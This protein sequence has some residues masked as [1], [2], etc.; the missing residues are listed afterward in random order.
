MVVK[1]KTE[2]CIVIMVAI[3]AVLVIFLINENDYTSSEKVIVDESN[4]LAGMASRNLQSNLDLSTDVSYSSKGLE[5]STSIDLC[6]DDILQAK[7]CGIAFQEDINSLKDEVNSLN[8]FKF[9]FKEIIQEDN[10]IKLIQPHTGVK[11]NYVNCPDNFLV[12]G[13]GCSNKCILEEDCNVDYQ[14]KIISSYPRYDF[15]NRDNLISNGWFCENDYD[16]HKGFHYNKQTVYALCLKE[17]TIIASSP[18]IVEYQDPQSIENDFE[19][20]SV[21]YSP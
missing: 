5:A 2:L 19:I 12:I 8:F 11:E 7:E 6:K 15:D 9:L 4:N 13:G 18:K 21:S 1:N 10:F 14:S 3:V 20:V 17:G 16:P